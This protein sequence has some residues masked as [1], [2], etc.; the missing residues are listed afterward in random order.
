MAGAGGLANPQAACLK[1]N[2]ITGIVVLSLEVNFLFLSYSP[3]YKDYFYVQT[4]PPLRT[5]HCFSFGFPFWL[6]EEIACFSTS[7]LLE[8][9]L[10][11]CNY[12]ND[13]YTELHI[14]IFLSSLNVSYISSYVN[15]SSSFSP[16]QYSTFITLIT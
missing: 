2:I 6:L 15:P 14:K 3:Q 10:Y 16:K 8:Y 1:Q 13:L 11:V 9:V 4:G 7:G 5:I 12:L